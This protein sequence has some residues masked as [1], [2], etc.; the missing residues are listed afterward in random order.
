MKKKNHFLVLS[1]YTGIKKGSIL[2][3]FF[4]LIHTVSAQ[5]ADTMTYH[6]KAQ[7][8]GV[9][10]KTNTTKSFLANNGLQYNMSKERTS[11][12]WNGSWIYGKQ[13]GGITN[14]DFS[15]IFDYNFFHKKKHAYVWGFAAYDKSYSLKIIDRI[16]AGAGLGYKLVDTKVLLLDLS[17]GII[18]ENSDLDQSADLTARDIETFRNSLRLKYTFNYS[19]VLVLHGSNYWQQ[20]VETRDDY[21]IKCYNTLNIKVRKW[22]SISVVMN[23][24]KINITQRENFLL[25]YGLT[26]DKTF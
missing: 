17:D 10:N 21:I 11:I 22:L 16:Q 23:Y 1:H 19:T 25:T 18:Y 7:L 20:S 4:L 8:A 2:F 12:N 9:F 6:V 13:N 24:N 3:L 15:S 26:F 5:Y 14:N